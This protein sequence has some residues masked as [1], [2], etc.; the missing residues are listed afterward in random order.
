M[1]QSPVYYVGRLVDGTKFRTTKK[2]DLSYNH[3]YDMLIEIMLDGKLTEVSINRNKV[4]F[5]SRSSRPTTD[6]WFNE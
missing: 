6:L 1:K 2:Y 5:L 4:I 3:Q